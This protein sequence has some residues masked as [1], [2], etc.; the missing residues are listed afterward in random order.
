M[1]SG[2]HIELILFILAPNAKSLEDSSSSFQ[3]SVQERPSLRLAALSQR[4]QARQGGPQA[5]VRAFSRFVPP[6]QQL[7][8]CHLLT[9]QRNPPTTTGNAS[10]SREQFS[11]I[12]AMPRRDVLLVGPHKRFLRP[13]NSVNA[14][15]SH[16]RLS[17]P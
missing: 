13:A 14:V 17:P 2:A 5:N 9:S 1:A 3:P 8:C 11:T 12:P 15:T 7:L 4:C 16:L 6:K 10:A